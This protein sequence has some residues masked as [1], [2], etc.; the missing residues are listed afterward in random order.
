MNVFVHEWTGTQGT[1]L[2]MVDI[3]DN[4]HATVKDDEGLKIDHRWRLYFEVEATGK[5]GLDPYNSIRLARF[6]YTWFLKQRIF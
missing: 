3:G 1:A 4:A 5:S 6:L 2:A